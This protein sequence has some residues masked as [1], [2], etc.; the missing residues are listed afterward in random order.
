VYTTLDCDTRNDDDDDDS[1]PV[2]N[3]HN[4]LIT[5]R[6]ECRAPTLEDY[7]NDDVDKDGG[8]LPEGLGAIEFRLAF[9]HKIFDI[10]ITESDHE[11]D[12]ID[13]D[14]DTLVDEPDED[15]ANGRIANCNMT[16]VTENFIMFGCVSSGSQLGH[17]YVD[18]IPVAQVVVTPEDDLRARIRPG[19]DNGV[20]RTLLLENCQIADIYGDIFP[21]TYAGLTQ[22]CTDLDV[23][24][25]RLEGD[26]DTDC[27]VS[28]ADAQ[29]TA[30]RYGSFFGHLTYDQNYDLEPFTTTDFDIDIKDLQ[31]VFGRLGSTCAAPIP[32]N[33]DP[34]PAAGVG[35]P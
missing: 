1:H 7:I 31:F 20:S 17:P 10:V 4:N 25:R 28:I 34:I 12:G 23:T 8:E 21:N 11:S 26:V 27:D 15:W 18:G 13:N 16:I 5:F 2:S 3:D 9:D 33:Q 24:V 22:D 32:N 6:P 30:F 29:L 35:Q 19:K 14:A